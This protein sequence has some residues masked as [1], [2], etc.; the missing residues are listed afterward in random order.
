MN[1]LTKTCMVVAT[2][3]LALLDADK[4]LWTLIDLSKN[5]DGT[6]EMHFQMHEEMNAQ[7]TVM[8]EALENKLID[9]RE[10]VDLLLA[11]QNAYRGKH[12]KA[13]K[14]KQQSKTKKI[15]KAEPLN[16][17]QYRVKDREQN[18]IKR[19]RVGMKYLGIAVIVS[20]VVAAMIFADGFDI[21][22]DT[23]ALVVV[24]GIGIGHALGAK[25]RESAITR[26]GDGCVRGGWLGLLI[27]LALIAG[28][29]IGAAM[30][31]SALMPALSVASLTPLYGYF[32]KIITM[33]LD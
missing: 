13:N 31:F 22:T 30:D 18:L 33:Q 10:R 11:K 8:T 16:L 32:I 1:G 28:S 29:P 21:L 15:Q 2:I 5:K 20:T 3:P 26:F 6:Y 27:G 12:I 17:Q 4:W 25:D 7:Q 19:R 24:V 9:L 23:M 14:I